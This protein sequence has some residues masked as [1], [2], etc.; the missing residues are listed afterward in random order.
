MFIDIFDL[1]IVFRMKI[2]CKMSDC[3]MSGYHDIVRRKTEFES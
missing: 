2:V 1:T 3:L